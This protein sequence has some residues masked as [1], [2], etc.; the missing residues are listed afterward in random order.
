MPSR[1]AEAARG[2]FRTIR[3][4]GSGEQQLPR[5]PASPRPQ[6]AL[7]GSFGPRAAAAPS[8][9]AAATTWEFSSTGS[10]APLGAPPPQL[11]VPSPD[12]K[13]PKTMTRE[14]AGKMAEQQ[15]VAA[16]ELLTGL[17]GKHTSPAKAQAPGR[18]RGSPEQRMAAAEKRAAIALGT[19][20]GSPPLAQRMSAVVT[21]ARSVN[22]TERPATSSLGG[23][24]G[25]AVLEATA[26]A[27]GAQQA[28]LGAK[29]ALDVKAQLR[30]VLVQVQASR[31]GG[32]ALIA[33]DARRLEA[34]RYALRA[35]V[36]ATWSTAWAH[37]DI[38][39]DR[40]ELRLSFI[41]TGA[42]RDGPI[43][44]QQQADGAEAAEPQPQPA[45]GRHG[46]GCGHGARNSRRAAPRV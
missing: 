7:G 13:P 1:V 4:L 20:P 24:C 31:R 26:H 32:G 23:R 33:A 10:A 12:V 36:S 2:L 27:A 6:F 21:P 41:H 14:E 42:R 9:A 39:T 37:V 44:A 15:A 38:A 18:P 35:E 45:S 11:V 29:S 34:R 19:A 25:S 5:R 3:C 17:R 28:Y 8:S 22:P 16:S 30:A 40:Q 43:K 46:A